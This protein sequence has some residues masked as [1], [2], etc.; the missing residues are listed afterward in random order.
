MP[1]L[2]SSEQVVFITPYDLHTV[3]VESVTVS[4]RDGICAK[5]ILLLTGN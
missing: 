2:F 4:N 1:K 3:C 5:N